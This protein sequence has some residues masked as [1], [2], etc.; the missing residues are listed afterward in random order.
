MAATLRTIY[1]RQL[2]SEIQMIEAKCDTAH[3]NETDFEIMDLDSG[4]FE[5]SAAAS[6]SLL[7][8]ISHPQNLVLN[9]LFNL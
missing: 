3:T 2:R 5:D 9:N 4:G 7:I 1:M 8:S 6:A